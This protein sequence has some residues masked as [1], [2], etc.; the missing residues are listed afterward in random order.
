LYRGGKIADKA[1]TGHAFRLRPR[2]RFPL[3]ARRPRL[4]IS[5]RPRWCAGWRASAK[6]DFGVPV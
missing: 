6:C 1:L 4:T 5:G 3:I 2:P